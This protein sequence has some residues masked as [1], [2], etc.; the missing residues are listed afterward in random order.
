M[1]VLILMKGSVKELGLHLIIKNNKP[2]N[3]SKRM[4]FRN[5]KGLSYKVSQRQISYDI[6]YMWSL[7]RY[8]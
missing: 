4:L 8:E 1:C 7:K 3:N 2:I 5:M 6:T